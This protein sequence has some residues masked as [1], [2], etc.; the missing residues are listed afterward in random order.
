MIK[1]LMDFAMA[2]T[3]IT[4]II[5]VVVFGAMLIITMVGYCVEIIQEIRKEDET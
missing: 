4:L 2:V 3:L 1:F 5:I